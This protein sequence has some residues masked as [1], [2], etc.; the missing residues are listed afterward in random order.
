MKPLPEGYTVYCDES[1]HDSQ[2][3]NRYMAIGGLWVP[4]GKK[5]ALTKELRELLA[6]RGLR[7]EVKWTKTSEKHL[8]DYKAIVD[9]FVANELNFRVIVV[10]QRK[11]D[12]D[13]FKQ[14]DE[15]LGFYSF[16]YEMLIKWLDKPVTY[17][18]LLDFKK[19]KGADHYEVLARCLRAKV[20][21]ET[22]VSGVHVIDSADSPLAQLADLLTGAVA[23]S[24][25]GFPGITPKSQLADYIAKRLGRFSLRLANAGP[26]FGKFNIFRIDLQ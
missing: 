12:Y 8:E 10:D 11:V 18:L 4:T 25:C 13:R 20:P 16:Y 17:N 3:R 9:F 15:E 26:A 23:A 22:V 6:S 24:W 1:R 7:S 5:Q 21:A 19:N 2:E 14:G